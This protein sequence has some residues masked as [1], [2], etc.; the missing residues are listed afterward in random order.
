MPLSFDGKMTPQCWYVTLQCCHECRRND[1]GQRETTGKQTQQ[2]QIVYWSADRNFL[3][4]SLVGMQLLAHRHKS[5]THA[6]KARNDDGVLRVSQNKSA[7]GGGD[8]G[9]NLDVTV[10]KL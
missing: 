10:Q 8:A 4:L 3:V 9:V 1:L 6:N 2:E 7:G 5:G